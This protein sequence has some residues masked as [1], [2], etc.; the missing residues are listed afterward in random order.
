MNARSNV[1]A[2]RP[3]PPPRAGNRRTQVRHTCSLAGEVEIL[4]CGGH[5]KWPA[6]SQDLSQEG[7]GLILER[8]FE[9]GTMLGLLVH[10]PDATAP[11]TAVIRVARVEARLAGQ[12]LHG[13]QFPRNLEFAELAA[14]AHNTERPP[15]NS[16]R[17][18]LLSNKN[19]RTLTMIRERLKILCASAHP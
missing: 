15:S 9:P 12:W 16:S 2:L 8:R 5:S 11:F 17:Y 19:Q 7:I 18:F 1:Q 6:R 10:G 4:E 3:I 14:L 13:C